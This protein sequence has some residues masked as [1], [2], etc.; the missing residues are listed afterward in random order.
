MAQTRG[1]QP[2]NNDYDP[3]T[4]CRAQTRCV[5]P[6]CEDY[7]T[8]TTIKAQR[9]PLQ[10]LHPLTASTIHRRRFVQTRPQIARIMPPPPSRCVYNSNGAVSRKTTHLTTQTT[11]ALPSHCVYNPN[12]VVSRKLD[13]KQHQLCPLHPIAASTT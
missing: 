7:G 6:K 11:A 12:G 5:Q 13:P 3:M 4:T 1:L 9:Q 10:P 8:T 2:N